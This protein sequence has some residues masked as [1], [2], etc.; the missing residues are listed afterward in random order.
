M[1]TSVVVCVDGEG[2]KE[3]GR[4]YQHHACGSIVVT[5]CDIRIGRQESLYSAAC[6]FQ[7]ANVDVAV[8]QKTKFVDPT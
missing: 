6:A 4:K 3:E 7:E 1:P 8:M 2:T 5:M